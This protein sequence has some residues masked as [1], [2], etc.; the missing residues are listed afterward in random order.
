MAA[1][2]RT[3]QTWLLV[4]KPVWLRIEDL[5]RDTKFAKNV[6]IAHDGHGM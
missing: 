3:T 4:R 1:D 5:L 2:L 6:N